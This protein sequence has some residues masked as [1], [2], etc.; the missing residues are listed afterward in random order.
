M[1]PVK[2]LLFTLG[3]FLL[4]AGAMWLTPSKGVKIGSFTFHMPTFSE[5]LNED[6]VQYADVSNIIDQQFDIDSLLEQQPDS[7]L[8]DSVHEFIPPAR[9]DSLVKSIYKIELTDSARLNLYRFFHH[10]HDSA[11]T[12]IMHYGDSQLEGDRITA[13]LRNKFQVKFGGTGPGLRPAVQPYDYIFTAVQENSDNWKR[14]P[15]YGNV[16]TL[17]EHNRYGVMGAF[18]RY[19]PLRSDTLPFTD[20][21]FYRA[22]LS[23]SKSDIAFKR[24]QEYKNF[25]LFYGNTKRP[26]Q[27]KLMAKGEVV[28]T[29]TL[30][31]NLNYGVVE[32]AL[33]DST[34]SITLTFAGYDSP[35]VYGIDLASKTGVIVDNIA[36]RGSSG[37]IFTKMDFAHS[38]KMYNDLKP[39]LFILQFGGNV[40]PYI[41]DRK[42]IKNYGRWFTAQILRLQRICPE[43][44]IIVIGPSDMSTKE[45]DKYVTYKLLPDVVGTLKE[46]AQSNG[47]A[48]WNMYEA[49]GGHNSMPSW[50]NADPSLARPDYVHF[51]A[52]GARLIANMF[53]NALIFEYT[54]Y[55]TEQEKLAQKK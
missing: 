21:T 29:D 5:M 14:Y 4:L 45:K 32:S 44:A 12:R 37:T 36:L 47:C 40:V 15:I 52:K 27:M 24:T 49:M 28:L 3:V 51:S 13:F 55:L 22:E 34:G 31:Q 26:V 1:K 35:D 20:T 9:Y 10:L 42:A 41:K 8:A 16:D 46:V 50:V 53:Y 33:P 2:T 30:Q 43:A 38:Q 6:T 19:A 17:V 25:R 23:I 48:F 7:L 18:S 39:R 11:F 54:N